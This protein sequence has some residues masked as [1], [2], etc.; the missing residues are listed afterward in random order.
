MRGNLNWRYARKY[1]WYEK[2]ETL[3]HPP[4]SPFSFR[5]PSDGSAIPSDRSVYVSHDP[6]GPTAVVVSVIAGW[7]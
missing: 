4:E 3:T 1:R 6:F 5:F 2:Q 7:N